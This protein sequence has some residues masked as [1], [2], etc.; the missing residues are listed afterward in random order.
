M[1]ASAG[2][3]IVGVGGQNGGAG[4]AWFAPL[5]T[6]LPTSPLTALDVAFKD[7]GYVSTAGLVQAVNENPTDIDAFGVIVPVRT[8][9][10]KSKRTFKASFL[11]TNPVTIAVYNRKKLTAVTVGAAGVIATTLGAVDVVQYSAVFDIVDGSNHIRFVCP[12][13]QNTTISDLNIGAG[14]A[15]ERGVELTAFPDNSGIAIYEYDL[16]A[17]LS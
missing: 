3:V 14:A 12:V 7:A 13:V 17:A 5:G 16:V 11:E 1:V 8:V 10:T 2:N 6:A 4:V 15:V 9:T